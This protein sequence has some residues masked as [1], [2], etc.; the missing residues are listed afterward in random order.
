MKGY[1]VEETSWRLLCLLCLGL[2][3]VTR[4]PGP[5]GHEFG[6]RENTSE[7]WLFQ[8]EGTSASLLEGDLSLFFSYIG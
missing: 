7:Q 6:L 2:T 4:G 8:V 3:R 1:G 5:Q